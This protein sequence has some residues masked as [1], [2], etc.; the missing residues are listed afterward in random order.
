MSTPAASAA[1]PPPL[2]RRS[3][4]ALVR[5]PMTALRAA[6][7]IAT[8][9]VSVTV[10]SGVLMRFTDP[11]R[12]PNV[13]DGFWWAVQTVTTVGYGDIVPGSVAGR[14]L[15]SVVMLVG[16][17]FLTVVT[18]AITAT[19]I[20]GARRRLAAADTDSET[21]KLDQIAARLDAIEA[22]LKGIPGYRDVTRPEG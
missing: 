5:K 17:G 6:R 2:R 8:V 20:E 22:G 3:L 16:I 18:A 9:T 4:N 7:I 10:I 19:F 11:T 15:A 21:A 13:G 12:F 14:L 1:A